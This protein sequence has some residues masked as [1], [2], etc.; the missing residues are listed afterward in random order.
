MLSWLRTGIIIVVTIIL[1]RLIPFSPFFQ[2]VNTLIHELSHAI[3]A[4]LLKGSVM[5][6]HLFADQSGV[7]Y[8]TF[9]EGWMMIPIGLAGYIGSALFAVMLFALF[10]KNKI[11]AGLAIVAVCA[12]VALIL[13]VRNDYGAA[14]CAGF[15]I[16]TILVCWVAPGWLQKSYYLLIAFI[17]LVESIISSLII[18]LLS[19]TDPSAAGDAASL[20]SATFL[21]AAVW[22]VLFV[23]VSLW[24]ARVSI[25]QLFRRPVRQE[26]EY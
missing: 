9:A 10:A 14:W 8:T 22:A 19:L 6:I 12:G 2:N 24:C 1:T 5:Q 21:P 13:F 3:I 7:T 11:R 17:C 18:L 16:I 23:A 15:T 26:Q 25:A 20:S 4:L